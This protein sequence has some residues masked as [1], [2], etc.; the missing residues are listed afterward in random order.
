MYVGET[1]INVDR[2]AQIGDE[3]IYP[4]DDAEDT[5]VIFRAL[6]R[7]HGRCTGCVYVDAEY[8]STQKVGWVF[9]KKRPY[10][11]VPDETYTH[12]VWVTLYRDVGDYEY[13][14]V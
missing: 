14:G 7:E 1:H 8:G 6:Q 10:E 12:E 4:I 13:L 11:D 2:N 9:R 3:Y 5:S